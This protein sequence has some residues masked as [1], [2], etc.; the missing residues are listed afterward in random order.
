MLCSPCAYVHV[1]VTV[2]VYVYVYV[3]LR[4]TKQY[5]E[6]PCLGTPKMYTAR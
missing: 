1:S 3:I 6:D 2:N 5:V 4:T